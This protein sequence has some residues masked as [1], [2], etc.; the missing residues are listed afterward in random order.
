M[1]GL[2]TI[3][4]LVLGE[5]RSITVVVLTTELWRVCVVYF[6]SKNLRVPGLVGGKELDVET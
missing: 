5:S 3:T 4:R 6:T 1:H 2:V